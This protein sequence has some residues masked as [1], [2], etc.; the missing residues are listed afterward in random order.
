M[1]VHGTPTAD[2]YN[3]LPGG[4]IYLATPRSHL[5]GENPPKR[6]HLAGGRHPNLLI[7]VD[8]SSAFDLLVNRTRISTVCALV[9]LLGT[10]DPTARESTPVALPLRGLRQIENWSGRCCP[11]ADC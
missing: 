6:S 11:E 3:E 9:G 4:P 8:R 10:F 2:P 7:R 5:P 1:T